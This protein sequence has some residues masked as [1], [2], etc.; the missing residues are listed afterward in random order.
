MGSGLQ[1]RDTPARPWTPGLEAAQQRL[2]GFSET[3]PTLG[4]PRLWASRAGGTQTGRQSMGRPV[5]PEPGGLSPQASPEPCYE[6]P[7]GQ[8]G[9]VPWTKLPEGCPGAPH[10]P[11]VP[12]AADS[13]PEQ[14]DLRAVGPAWPVRTS[15]LGTL[16]PGSHWEALPWGPPPLPHTPRPLG[17]A[18]PNCTH[19]GDRV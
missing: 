6:L 4:H 8:R 13:E 3:A 10:R 16:G 9:C 17:N 12:P 15:T 1:D 18:T 5:A 7:G 19:R 14:G 11:R 2:T